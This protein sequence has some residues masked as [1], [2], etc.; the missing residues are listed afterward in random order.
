FDLINWWISQ[1]PSKVS[2]FGHLN[3]YGPK[4]GEF[5]GKRCSECEYADKCEFC[6]KLSDFEKSFYAANEQYDG[7]MKDNC[8][9]ADDIDIYD[10]MAVTVEY[11][12][13]AVL[14]Y[15]LNATTPYE[16]W[17][18]VINGSK[19]R[20]EATE[21]ETG[22]QSKV[23]EDTFKVF[24]LANNITEYHVTRGSGGHGGGDTRLHKMIFTDNVPDP[25]GHKA[26]TMDGAYSILVGTAA[27]KSIK[28]SRIVTIDELLKKPK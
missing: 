13:G 19:G 25:M 2:A 7:Y 24:D 9:Y 5:K 1:K 28:E 8:V 20:L 12:K 3:L 16:G 11:D 26:G 4:N 23:N 15:S 27:N 14:T 17:K 18:M 10:T 21:F 6:Y 22:V